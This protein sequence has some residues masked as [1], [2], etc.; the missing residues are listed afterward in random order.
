MLAGLLPK[1][2][3]RIDVAGVNITALVRDRLLGLRVV[4]QEGFDADTLNFEIDN[5]DQLVAIPPAEAQLKLWLGLKGAP[6]TNMGSFVVSRRSGSYTPSRMMI[7]AEAAALTGAI[8]APRTRAWT[9]VTLG[10]VVSTIASAHGLRATVAAQIA[11]ID[12]GYVAQTAESD[13]HLLTRLS[14]QLAVTI[15]PVAGRLIAV[16]F[17]APINAAGTR[18]PEPLIALT[19]CGIADWGIDDREPFNSVEADWGNS[20]DGEVETVTVGS[21]TPVRRLRHTFA[22][23]GEAQR[24]A[25]AELR[26]ARREAYTM[27]LDLDGFYPA[28]F[29]GGRARLVGFKPE[30]NGVWEVRSVTHSLSEALRTTAELRKTV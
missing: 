10:D 4:D 8:R 7:D 12:L 29:A 3:F 26:Y 18:L 13:L 19:N 5:R 23:Q 27:S 20:D 2:D 11:S 14:R 6:L 24:A 17:G 16:P 28:L 15:K 25:A 1:P 22:T 21:G 30:H 9:D